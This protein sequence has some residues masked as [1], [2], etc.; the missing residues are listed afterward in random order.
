[1]TFSGEVLLRRDW[2]VLQV[3]FNT[4]GRALAI[5]PARGNAQ[6]WDA[7]KR[8]PVAGASQRHV[9]RRKRRQK[10]R[11]RSPLD[12]RHVEIAECA[13][14]SPDG[15]TLAVGGYYAN[16]IGDPFPPVWVVSLR[17]ARTGAFVGEPFVDEIPM[18]M[19]AGHTEELTCI[20]FS[21]DGEVVATASLDGTVRLWDVATGRPGG[22]LHVGGEEAYACAF[23]PDG[24]LLATATRAYAEGRVEFW[25]PDARSERGE[26]LEELSEAVYGLAFSPDGRVLATAD[27]DGVRLW[28]VAA[29]EPLGGPLTGSSARGL[30]FSPDGR[31]LAAAGAD[32]TIRLW[33]ASD[34]RPLG[35]PLSGHVG[36][37][38][39]VSFS[40]D[41]LLL[42]SAGDDGT[43]RLWDAPAF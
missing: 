4:A 11:G 40:A 25:T 43:A 12:A 37:V 27:D 7:A 15:R 38:N 19:S 3:A 42:A 32:G 6:L 33:D 34:R 20:A 23:S 2:P 22:R 31:T 41:G 30:A 28:D 16:S 14:F 18:P 35:D 10:R 8:E 39:S 24:R 9:S 29:R 1:M 5:V 21:P 17:D 13:A 26:P 36:P